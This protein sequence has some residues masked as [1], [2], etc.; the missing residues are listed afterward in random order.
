MTA[1]YLQI[2]I[3]CCCP[4][5]LRADIL[6]LK[7]GEILTG[8]VEQISDRIIEYTLPG[9]S[10]RQINRDQVLFTL[11]EANGTRPE[12]LDSLN[13]SWLK[14]TFN[15]RQSISEPVNANWQFIR[16]RRKFTFEAN[17]N[18]WQQVIQ[19]T[20][21]AKTS[22][23]HGYLQRFHFNA[24]TSQI[25]DFRAIA[26]HPDGKIVH[27]APETLTVRSIQ[28]LGA[29]WNQFKELSVELPKAPAGAILDVKLTLQT[30][31]PRAIAIEHTFCA[32]VPVLLDEI[33]FDSPADKTW[34]VHPQ[35]LNGGEKIRYARQ[36]QQNRVLQSWSSEQAVVYTP[37]LIQ[38]PPVSTYP[39]VLLHGLSGFWRNTIDELR[40]YILRRKPAAKHL[41][42]PPLT[43]NP[44]AWLESLQQWPILN[45]PGCAALNLPVDAPQ[46][47]IASADRLTTALAVS[48]VLKN[49]D[50]N[51]ELLLVAP[52]YYPS[53]DKFLHPH[54]YSQPVIHLKYNQQ[55]HYFT[56]SETLGIFE[57]ILPEFLNAKAL[58]VYN[59]QQ[60]IHTLPSESPRPFFWK[61]ELTFNRTSNGLTP[62][63]WT[64][65]TNTHFQPR[66]QLIKGIK[67][68]ITALAPGVQLKPVTNQPATTHTLHSWQMDWPLASLNHGAQ[69]QIMLPSAP[70]LANLSSLSAHPFYPPFPGYYQFVCRFPLNAQEVPDYLTDNLLIERDSYLIRGYYRLLDGYLEKVMLIHFFAPNTD[71]ESCANDLKA[72]LRFNHRPLLFKQQTP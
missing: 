56:V 50:Y 33:V 59:S 16:R 57:G 4:I 21:T 27:Y 58:S 23:H 15:Q 14:Q 31:S 40:E 62:L 19:R 13:D 69:R 29:P 17:A 38:P 25:I 55:D 37:S 43:Q 2:L 49:A 45:Y 48:Q 60:H 3:L 26:I 39:T 30:T 1:K 61:H 35:I 51:V 24:L 67:N 8:K 63:K 52:A 54:W 68:A 36:L 34:K 46:A 41:Q 47:P 42:L 9:E 71:P 70:E 22:E 72:L 6:G 32:E 65:S 66:P 18:Q 12:D 64:F 11:I 28:P 10:G 20:L 44:L 53:P 5:L 7:N